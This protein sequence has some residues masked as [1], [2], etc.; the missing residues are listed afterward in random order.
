MPAM[1]AAL[2]ARVST[3]DKDQN[4]ETQLRAL[5]AFC[6]AQ[7]YE[8]AGEYVDNASAVDTKG[9]TAWRDLFNK[10]G[11]YDVLAVM[12]IDRAWRSVVMMLHDLDELDR[13]GKLFVAITQPI[14]TRTSVG[15]LSLNILSA[16][17]EFERELI[18]ERTLEGLARA[19]AE[20]QTLGRP[21]NCRCGHPAKEHNK[22]SATYCKHH[23]CHCSRYGPP[24]KGGV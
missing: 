12:K 7:G 10:S 5:R 1:R 11:S 22:G 4:P 15:R 2:Y 17:A 6:E 16:V 8:I 20:G 14:D 21:R 23:G 13:R 24:K 9:R 3:I 18:S 19:R